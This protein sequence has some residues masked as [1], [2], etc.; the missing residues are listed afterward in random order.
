M[1]I[2]IVGECL[3]ELLLDFGQVVVDDLFGL[4][5]VQL[6][7]RLDLLGKDIP[8]AFLVLHDLTQ[9]VLPGGVSL[10]DDD[11]LEEAFQELK[12]PDSQVGPGPE[13]NIN[14]VVELF[15]H[16]AYLRL[17]VHEV[18][19]AGSLVDGDEAVADEL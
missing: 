2:L 5:R 18:V 11:L 6:H 12:D 16:A 15:V 17:E 13:I 8:E 10:L 14:S 9:L 3:D 19:L 4:G 1:E 7:Q